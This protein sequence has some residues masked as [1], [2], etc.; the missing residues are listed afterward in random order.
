MHFLAIQAFNEMFNDDVNEVEEVIRPSLMRDL[1]KAEIRSILRNTIDG[2][3]SDH[4]DE[5]LVVQKTTQSSI[6]GHREWF[7]PVDDNQYGGLHEKYR[8]RTKEYYL[9]CVFEKRI[10]RYY[11]HFFENLDNDESLSFH[12]N[13][14]DRVTEVRNEFQIKKYNDEEN[15]KYFDRTNPDTRKCTPLGD[16]V[17]MCDE[18]V[19]Y[20]SINPYKCRE[21]R[22]LFTS[23][24]SEWS[25]D[26]V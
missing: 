10:Q 23:N 2:E 11:S 7:E 25:L 16:V 17:C 13:Y 14:R 9:N 18:D 20:H 26:H 5:N 8:N 15:R 3:P 24:V 6:E 4:T 12:P 1:N 19:C 21:Q 22:L